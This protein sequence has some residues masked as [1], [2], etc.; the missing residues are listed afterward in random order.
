MA[1]CD[2]ESNATSY[3]NIV[4]KNIYGRL[5]DLLLPLLLLNSGGA[6]R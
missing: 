2:L 4:S 1:Y 5:F 3:K 6:E